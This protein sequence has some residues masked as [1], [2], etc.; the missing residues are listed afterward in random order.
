LTRDELA[1]N[2]PEVR[3][4][5]AQA[6]GADESAE[7][8]ALIARALGDS[9]W[10]V[11]KEAALA[12]MAA[13]RRV[14]VLRELLAALG[15]R[16]NVGL[17]NSAVE[18]LVAIGPDAVPTSIAALRTLDADGRKL[19]IEALGGIPDAR[20]AEA[21]ASA[22]SD[23]DPNV[24]Q[25]AAE[26]LGAAAMAGD[27]A[28]KTAVRALRSILP[29][30]EPMLTLAA[31]GALSRIGVALDWAV[32][33]PLTEDSLLRS[34]ALAS[35]AKCADVAAAMALVDAL[36]DSNA[37]SAR[38]ALAALAEWI[39]TAMRLGLSIDELA[40]RLQSR[41]AGARVHAIAEGDPDSRGPALTLLALLG[42]AEAAPAIVRALLD[43]MLARSAETAVS[44]LGAAAL[45]ALLAVGEREP[46]PRHAALLLV[47]PTL[48][49]RLD[50]R[51]LTVVR[52]T[53]GHESDDVAAAAAQVL[54]AL[55]DGEDIERLALLATSERGRAAGSAA[56]SI[57]QLAER[58]RDEA[59]AAFARLSGDP[60]KTV[61]GCVLLAALRGS[62]PS[63]IE[64]LK[65][66]LGA[67]DVRAR[68]A[69]IEAFATIGGDRSPHAAA[70]AADARDTVASALA[71]EERDVQLAA[72]R[73]LGVLR[74]TNAL[75][76]LV[77]SVS[78]PEI[79]AAAA[80]ALSEADGERALEV[81]TRLLAREDPAIASA[82]VAALGRLG[83][84][85]EGGL[86]RA[87]DHASDEVVKLALSELGRAPSPRALERV[88][89]SLEHPS[90]EVRRLA[91]EVLGA[92]G[93]DEAGEILRKRLEHENDAAVR[94]AIMQSLAG[95]FGAVESA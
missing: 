19:A 93:S 73:A 9:D 35:C 5:A 88:G 74:H 78:D 86:V 33:A 65:A 89:K 8:P 22:L 61:A 77:D 60:S 59:L 27:D 92:E 47:V 46:P 52:A 32:L 28:R 3:R 57:E 43:P 83:E 12:A 38:A 72:I 39:Q 10:R 85:A 25:A 79:V 55:G 13:P 15:D 42:D 80:S 54:G 31:L 17:R 18:A 2:D 16:D 95:P 34:A 41:D 21:L 30:A 36:F 91:A 51:A 64:Y 71:D 75:S 87:L 49:S 7:A 56:L 76:G 45:P 20:G 1:S 90:W 6:L 81:C 4:L 23:E 44:L 26:A 53:L 48:T 50:D 40:G 69:A 70:L 82:A 24:R 68:R 14:D 58:H 37:A 66:A 11:R 84:R 94:D 67:G 63:S 29:R 62:P